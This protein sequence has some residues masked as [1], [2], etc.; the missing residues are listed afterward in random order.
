MA[1]GDATNMG[2]Y[3]YILR[4]EVPG[5][6]SIY[7]ALPRIG[8]G[9]VF[10]CFLQTIKIMKTNTTGKQNMS[11]PQTNAPRRPENKDNLDSRE[12]LEQMTKG[13]DVTHNKKETRGESK[14]K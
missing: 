7:L 12:N 3:T 2:R 6:P 14:K 5:F 8:T 4:T 9:I 1:T 10:T 11:K 13:D